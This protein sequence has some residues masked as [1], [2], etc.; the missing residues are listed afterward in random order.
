MP[1]AFL[2]LLQFAV[3]T[4]QCEQCQEIHTDASASTVIKPSARTQGVLV[5]NIGL[6]QSTGLKTFQAASG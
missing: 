3:V 2:V 6:L 1:S 5:K 4:T